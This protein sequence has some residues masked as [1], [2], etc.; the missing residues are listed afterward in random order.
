MSSRALDGGSR[1]MGSGTRR[2]SITTRATAQP[3]QLPRQHDTFSVEQSEEEPED[4]DVLSTRCRSECCTVSD[5]P[6]TASDSFVHG[7]SDSLPSDSGVSD[8][9]PSERPSRRDARE[10]GDRTRRGT[11]P[12][13]AVRTVARRRRSDEPEGEPSRNRWRCRRGAARTS[14]TRLGHRR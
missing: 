8:S 5:T 3:T 11:S 13:G 12:T 9:S 10:H 14:Q 6:S 7:V 1:P 2:T 4:G